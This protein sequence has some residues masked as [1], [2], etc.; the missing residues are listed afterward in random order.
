MGA[1]KHLRCYLASSTDFFIAYKQGGFNFAA[2]SD[3]D[4]G[5]NPNNAKSTSPY[6][7]MLANG[8]IS[9]SGTSSPHRSINHGSEGRRISSND[10]RSR[11]LQEHNAGIMIQGWIRQ[12][13][14]LHRQHV[15]ASSCHKIVPTTLEQS[16]KVVQYSTAGRGRHD[17]H[18]RN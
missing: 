2:F 11:L 4:W 15:G 6:I 1:A 16:A 8:T 13:T 14:A 17:H 9:F 5:N 18:P 10:K 12:C 3:A 7:V